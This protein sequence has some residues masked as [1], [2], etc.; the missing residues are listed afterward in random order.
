VKHIDNFEDR[1]KEGTMKRILSLAAVLILTA[2]VYGAAPQPKSYQELVAHYMAAHKAKNIQKIS[3]L[4]Y[5]G[6]IPD[7]ERERMLSNIKHN[8]FNNTISSIAIEEVPSNF[9]M[10]NNRYMY[11]FAPEKKIVVSFKK[12]TKNKM[13]VSAIYY[14]GMK[15]SV[16]YILFMSEEIK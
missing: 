4:I 1:I 2:M 10:K 15:D 13:L 8:T 9:E 6:S 12:N 11:P 14:A 3:A 5:W 16:A 7:E